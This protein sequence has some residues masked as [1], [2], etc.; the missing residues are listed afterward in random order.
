MMKTL[1]LLMN[2]AHSKDF[3]RYLTGVVVLASLPVH[4]TDYRVKIFGAKRDIET[5]S[6]GRSLSLG[7][8]RF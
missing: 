3:S 8:S 5:E 6:Y 2:S 4:Y 1:C 7:C